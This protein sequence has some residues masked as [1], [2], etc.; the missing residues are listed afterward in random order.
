MPWDGPPPPPPSTGDDIGY[1]LKYYR[2][3]GGVQVRHQRVGQESCFER[4]FL[5]LCQ[6]TRDPVTGIVTCVPRCVAPPPMS[7]VCLGQG[8]KL[9]QAAS[10][11]WGVNLM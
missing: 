2:L 5:D 11:V 10:K 6:D 4:R 3:V 7:C 1:V 9:T 8:F